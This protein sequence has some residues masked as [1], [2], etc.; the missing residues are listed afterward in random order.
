MSSA[1]GEALS[2][3][4]TQ[5]ISK[6]VC[7]EKLR[8]DGRGLYDL[9]SLRLTFGTEFGQ[10]QVQIGATK[11]YVTT[12]CEVVE[13]QQDK[14]SE[15]FFTFNVHFSPISS[16]EYETLR[17]T[18]TG[19]ELGRVVERGLRQSR[20]IDTEALCIVS[21]EKVWSIRLDIRILD[22]NGNLTDCC[23]IAA[24]TALHHF[25]RP[26]ITIREKVI[27]HQ[28]WEKDLVPLSIHHMPMCVTFAIFRSEDGEEILVVDPTWKEEQVMEGK[29]TIIMNIHRELCG[30]QKSGGIPIHP[31]EILKAT[32]IAVVKVEELTEVIKKAIA[33][34]VKKKIPLKRMKN[35][36]LGTMSAWT[37]AGIG[38]SEGSEEPTKEEIGSGCCPPTIKFHHDVK[39]VVME[40]PSIQ[41]HV[42][43][44]F[45]DT[46]VA[47]DFEEFTRTF[48]FTSKNFFD[49]MEEEEE[50]EEEMEE[51]G[52]Q[53][54]DQEE[55]DKIYQDT[56]GVKGVE[57]G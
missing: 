10:V 51:N 32:K 47:R 14:P 38:A 57:E 17:P 39:S 43:P 49:D 46:A 35:E 45:D 25:R 3:N 2:V 33:D 18:P 8:L 20:A 23:S 29:M 50:E 36:G 21:G 19:I 30:I 37:S 27:I 26:D 48:K 22:D 31:A 28:P 12:T 52:E 4:E 56:N 53:K 40:Q 5:F 1:R 54:G 34:D 9:R 42:P 6:A 7:E 16:L 44:V 41:K 24:I 11:V 55:E 15:G 13:P